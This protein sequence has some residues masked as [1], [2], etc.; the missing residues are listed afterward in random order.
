[1]RV[2]RLARSAVCSGGPSAPRQWGCVWRGSRA[3]GKMS[4]P[5]EA[6]R[7]TARPSHCPS[8]HLWKAESFGP[9]FY[10]HLDSICDPDRC[11]NSCA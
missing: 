7:G 1:M 4:E 10:S 2:S 9:H 6:L 5:E 8:C 11:T 3:F